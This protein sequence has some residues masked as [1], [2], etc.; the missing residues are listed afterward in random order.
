MNLIKGESGMLKFIKQ[1]L[2]LAIFVVIVGFGAS[3]TM[4]A[5]LGIGAYDAAAMSISRAILVKVGTVGMCINSMCIILQMIF[6]KKEFRPIQFLQIGVTILIGLTINFFL[7][8]VLAGILIKQYFTRIIFL[9]I[10]YIICAFAASV[11][12]TINIITL[13]L[14]G[15]CIVLS[16]KLNKNFGKIRQYA[17]IVSI[18]VV[19]MVTIIFRT[20]LTLR[21]GT[22]IG[23][24]IFGPM[25]NG[26]MNVIKPVLQRYD[27][28][29]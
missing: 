1:T 17:D 10:G 28:I 9:I 29:T 20:E 15:F 24:L 21:E 14:E 13:P 22:I 5:D 2:L 19:V 16:N 6:L 12:M 27:I 7:Y 23:M 4:K 8:N 3:L 18:A 11:I 25:M 26:F